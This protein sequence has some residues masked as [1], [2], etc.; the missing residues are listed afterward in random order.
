[1]RALSLSTTLKMT[2]Q[3]IKCKTKAKQMKLSTA[4]QT[5]QELSLTRS[6]DAVAI[7]RTIMPLTHLCERALSRSDTMLT[8]PLTGTLSQ[9][10]KL[11]KMQKLII[12]NRRWTL[13]IRLLKMKKKRAHQFSKTMIE[14]T[15]L[16]VAK[17]NRETKLMKVVGTQR[18][19]KTPAIFQE[20]NTVIHLQISL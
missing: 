16:K 9:S 14:S 7:S 20:T 13:K 12:S 8:K 6:I 15:R 11:S 2:N 5:N 3:V 17:M 10:L 1:M 4:N 19:P 18:F